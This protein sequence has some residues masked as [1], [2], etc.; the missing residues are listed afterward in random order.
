VKNA[1]KHIDQPIVGY[2]LV[3]PKGAATGI[4]RSAVAGEV[5]GSGWRAASDM[6]AERHHAPAPLEPGNTSVG[7]L[8]LTADEIVLLNGRRGMVK[9]VATGLAGRAPR[10]AIAGVELGNGKLTAPLR[11]AWQ[12]G[13]AW[14]VDVPRGEAKRAQKLVAQLRG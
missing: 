10:S 2:C 9:P 8:A 13:S 1:D 12:D 14:E 11:V 4:V 3:M 5:G 6:A 7:M